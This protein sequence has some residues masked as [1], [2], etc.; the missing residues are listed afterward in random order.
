MSPN[1]IETIAEENLVH[2]LFPMVL[3]KL[4][5]EIEKHRVLPWKVII[6]HYNS[7]ILS[8]SDF[9]EFNHCFYI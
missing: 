6:L 5:G 4:K 2:F 7:Y 1:Q 3:S 9:F 8:L